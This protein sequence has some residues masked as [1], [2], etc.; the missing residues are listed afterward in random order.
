MSRLFIN[1]FKPVKIVYKDKTELFPHVSLLYGLFHYRRCIGERDEPF[2]GVGREWPSV[3]KEWS[4]LRRQYASSPEVYASSFLQWHLVP[5]F[6]VHQRCRARMH[7]SR[8]TCGPLRSPAVPCGPLRWSHP[9]YYVP[10]HL[11]PSGDAPA[12]VHTCNIG[13]IFRIKDS[14][15]CKQMSAA[16]R[17]EED[18][19]KNGAKRDEQ[20]RF[21]QMQRTVHV[22]RWYVSKMQ[23]GP[24]NRWGARRRCIVRFSAS[25]QV[26][27]F[28]EGY[29]PRRT[30][31]SSSPHAAFLDRRCIALRPSVLL[32]LCTAGGRRCT[33]NGGT[34][35]KRV[36]RCIAYS[37]FHFF[38]TRGVACETVRWLCTAGIKWWGVVQYTGGEKRSETVV[39]HM[40]HFWCYKCSLHL[41]ESS[42][43]F[44]SSFLC[45]AR[46]TPTAL[47]HLRCYKCILLRTKKKVQRSRCTEGAKK[48]EEGGT[49]C[50]C[51][52]TS[53]M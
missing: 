24:K 43:F 36:G 49:Q 46:C 29:W 51:G 12:V 21:D 9:S 25:P 1:L 4:P 35:V 45:E 17:S 20:R 5:F 40:L 44:A 48:M 30:L 52:C 14:M 27:S 7:L 23:K 31:C 18:V 8:Y 3:L 47:L 6:A 42:L 28:A 15:R 26:P 19:K 16:V 32:L 34:Q 41:I 50:T 38:F 53:S 2:G 37:P 10:V 22:Q 13:C 11:V 33:W 39:M